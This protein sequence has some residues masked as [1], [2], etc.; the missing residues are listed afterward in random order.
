MDNLM[1]LGKK[2]FYIPVVNEISL[3]KKSEKKH[4][5]SE[6]SNFE[7]KR[8]WSQSEEDIKREREIFNDILNDE[9]KKGA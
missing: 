5:S 3:E 4:L 9:M 6:S 7:M 2:V 8:H 1:V